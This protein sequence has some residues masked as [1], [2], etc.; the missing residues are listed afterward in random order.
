MPGHSAAATG[1]I[2]MHYMMLF[3]CCECAYYAYFPERFSML[4]TFLGGGSNTWA[5]LPATPDGEHIKG[6][7]QRNFA[8]LA[9]FGM[10]VGVC[11]RNLIWILSD[12]VHLQQTLLMRWQKTI[13]YD[14]ARAHSS[15]ISDNE[16]L[17]CLHQISSMIPREQLAGS[18]WVPPQFLP[19]W[20]TDRN[21]T[22]AAEG[23]A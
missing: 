20:R 3:T 12:I 22:I 17:M 9:T 15:F 4:H 19:G 13:D 7:M 16:G 21:V 10:H 5:N 18:K 2:V 6:F 11:V 23:F 14:S 1:E 8:L